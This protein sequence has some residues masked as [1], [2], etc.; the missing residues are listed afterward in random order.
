MTPDIDRDSDQKPEAER[1][2]YIPPEIQAEDDIDAEALLQA[3]ENV[4]QGC[5]T[6]V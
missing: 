3:P 6:I 2:A 4:I 1:R 5:S